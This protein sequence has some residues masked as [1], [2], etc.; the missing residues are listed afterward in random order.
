M[1]RNIKSHTFDVQLNGAVDVFNN[2]HAAVHVYVA[3]TCG[4]GLMTGDLTSCGF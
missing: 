2:K 1:K 3:E 4:W